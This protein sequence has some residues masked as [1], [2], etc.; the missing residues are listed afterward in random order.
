MGLCPVN[1]FKGSPS[2]SFCLL[3][4]FKSLTHC[5]QQTVR[6]MNRF[7]AWNVHQRTPGRRKAHRTA[8]LYSGQKHIRRAPCRALSHLSRTSD[9]RKSVRGCSEHTLCLHWG[10]ICLCQSLDDS[11]SAIATKGSTELGKP[12]RKPTKGTKSS[13]PFKYSISPLNYMLFFHWALKGAK[14]PFFTNSQT[15]IKS[16][17]RK[18]IKQVL[19]SLSYP[20][21]FFSLVLT[22]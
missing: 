10:L 7:D 6:K 4:V 14:I 17:K 5:F 9:R 15:V 16:R 22:S 20:I 12:R 18:L 13:V 21:L 19:G 1:E 3:N 8:G 11:R 2:S